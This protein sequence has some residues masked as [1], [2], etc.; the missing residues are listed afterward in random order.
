M[1]LRNLVQKMNRNTAVQF[2]LHGADALPRLE[3]QTEFELY[4]ICPELINNIIKRAGATNVTIGITQSPN[5]LCLTVTD[6]GTG[7]NGHQADGKGLQNVAAVYSGL[8]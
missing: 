8:K 6:D 2:H 4:S 5:A 3:Q 1:T 7:L